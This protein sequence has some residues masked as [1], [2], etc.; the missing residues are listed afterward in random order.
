MNRQIETNLTNNYMGHLRN[1]FSNFIKIL[2]GNFKPVVTYD[3]V[4]E[5]MHNRKHYNIRDGFR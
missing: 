4:P 2:T 5:P 1:L 3:R